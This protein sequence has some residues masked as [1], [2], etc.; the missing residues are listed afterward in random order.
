MTIIILKIGQG[1]GREQQYYIYNWFVTVM[2][3]IKRNLYG[4]NRFVLVSHLKFNLSHCCSVRVVLSTLT[5]SLPQMMACG[6][7]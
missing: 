3:E 7:V 1:S 5:P 4:L 2:L 6:A